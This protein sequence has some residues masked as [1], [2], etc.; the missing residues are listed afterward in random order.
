MTPL[1]ANLLK[2]AVE[3]V[4]VAADAAKNKWKLK[5]KIPHALP[6]ARED[7]AEK[8][9]VVEVVEVAVAEAAAVVVVAVEKVNK[10]QL[11]HLLQRQLLEAVVLCGSL[12]ISPTRSLSPFRCDNTAEELIMKVHIELDPSEP[13][14][15][16]DRLF[17]EMIL[18]L[19]GS[20]KEE[21]VSQPIHSHEQNN[22]EPAEKEVEPAVAR[23]SYKPK[24]C[25][26]GK[27]FIP[28]AGR[29][30]R[31]PDCIA[32][33]HPTI[34]FAE[35]TNAT[36]SKPEPSKMVSCRSCHRLYVPKAGDNNLYCPKCIEKLRNAPKISTPKI[37]DLTVEDVMR[38]PVVDRYKYAYM[39]SYSER[40]KALSM[41]PVYPKPSAEEEEFFR[42]C[43]TG[44]FEE[45]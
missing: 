27:T 11:Q 31:C 3:I 9:D 22:P 21:S 38:L 20:K 40:Q 28:T 34:K 5:R 15:E 39:W 16:R 7:A 12:S 2:L 37:C 18:E 25:P 24:V 43:A 33:K 42:R 19:K 17:L 13:L 29:Q 26:C 6:P 4:V 32:K 10:F 14:T 1:M 44:D 30:I 36:G 41:K 35:I 23:R 8:A 45:D